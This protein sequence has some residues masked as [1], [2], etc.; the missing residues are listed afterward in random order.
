MELCNI[1][2]FMTL[3][4]VIVFR[5]IHVAREQCNTA[6]MATNF[7]I[8]YRF[9]A[10]AILLFYILQKCYPHTS[11]LRALLDDLFSH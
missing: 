11:S 8:W 7:E 4:R 10:A 9:R 6:V 2:A 5:G 3:K 1:L